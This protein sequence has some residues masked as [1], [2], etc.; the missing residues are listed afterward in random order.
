MREMPLKPV[1]R[2][3]ISVSDKSGIVELAR[4]LVDRGVEIISSDGTTAFLNGAGV[5][6]K[7]VTEVTGAAELLGG[8]VKTLH[9]A[10]HAA[11]LAD[12]NNPDQVAE[13]HQLGVID[14]LVINLYP[15][16]GFDIGGPALARAAAK[17]AEHVAVITTQDQYPELIANLDLGTSLE[18]RK[19][20]ALQALMMT[21]RYDMALLQERGVELRYGENPQQS[22]RLV[23]DHPHMILQGK[24]MSFNNYL[25]LDAAWKTAR[26]CGAAVAIVK[27]GIPSG[28]AQADSATKAFVSAWSCDPVSAFGGVVASQL[29]IDQSCAAEL[30]KVFIE[31]VA[32]PEFTAE[33]LAV[34]AQ[35]PNLRVVQLSKVSQSEFEIRTITGGFLMQTPDHLHNLNDRLANWRLVSGAPADENL[36]RDLQFAWS[37]CSM[38]RSNA[39][40]LV[41]DLKTIGVGAG[42]VSRVD[43][44]KLAIY[45]AE[46]HSKDQLSGSVAASDAFFPF[47]DA[48]EYLITAGVTAIVQPGG[49]LKDDAVIKAAQTA[50]LTM[51]LT[52]IRHFSH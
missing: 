8:K 2:A 38:S 1:S 32:A 20:W 47:P 33:A 5:A 31:V 34:L 11:L 21:A 22:G 45:R 51:Y 13:L 43:A 39:V 23:A 9:P 27:H 14:L 52:G 30:V 42:S 18:Q 49:S 40:V 4:E 35:K 50:G 29:T 12:H 6:A 17:N 7:S 46:Q 15:T 26:N 37:A 24:E 28:V 44:A 3:L 19:R 10:I 41:K 36:A 48:V 16:S 25:D